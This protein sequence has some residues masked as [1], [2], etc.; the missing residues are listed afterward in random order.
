MEINE[1]TEKI[2]LDG[3]LSSAVLSPDGKMLYV[4]NSIGIQYLDTE[5]HNVTKTIEMDG[6]WYGRIAVHSDGTRFY[7]L[8]MVDEDGHWPSVHVFDTRTGERIGV[9]ENVTK[10]PFPDGGLSDI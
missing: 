2:E 7:I 4:A 5:S 8:Y 10:Q 6:E 1:V 9:I 3:Q